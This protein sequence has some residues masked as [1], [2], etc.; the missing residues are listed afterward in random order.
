MRQKSLWL[1][2]PNG[3]DEMMM[4]ERWINELIFTFPCVHL[5]CSHKLLAARWYRCFLRGQLYV[6]HQ[7]HVRFQYV[8][9]ITCY[10]CSFPLFSDSSICLFEEH[11]FKLHVNYPF[12]KQFHK[13]ECWERILKHPECEVYGKI[14]YLLTSLLVYPAQL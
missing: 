2:P 4:D 3:N 14:L 12:L 8:L 6:N 1:H 9:P 5:F 13:I 7:F 10:T 11:S